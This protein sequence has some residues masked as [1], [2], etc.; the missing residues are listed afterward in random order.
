MTTIA[1]I[2]AWLVAG[3]NALAACVGAWQWWRVTPGASFWFIARAAQVLAIVQALVAGGLALAGFEPGNWLYWLYA[4]LPV[5]VGFIAE[6]VR[7]ASAEDVL[8]Q[9]GLPDAQ[10]MG[11]LDERG[12]RSVVIAIM[13]RELG[14]A[15]IAAG[16]VAFLALRAIVEI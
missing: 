10:A 4:L 8:E 12:Q 2:M 11:E 7:I 3:S 1:E 16:V 14:V 15:A 13:R 9:R 6:G 5:L